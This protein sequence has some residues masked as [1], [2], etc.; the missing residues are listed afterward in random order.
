MKRIKLKSYQNDWYY[1]GNRFKILLWFIVNVLFF[2]NPLNGSS[3]IKVFFLRLFGAKVGHNITIKPAVN[4]KYPWR[5]SIGNNVWIG[6]NVWIDNLANVSIE[7]NV[8]LSQEAFLLTG[9]SQ[10]QTLHL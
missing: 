5:L 6:E 4:I 8:C 1:P 9:K 10:L 2:K 7:D 3:R